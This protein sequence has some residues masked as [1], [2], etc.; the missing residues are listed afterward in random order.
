MHKY[1]VR[2]FPVQVKYS[3]LKSLFFRSRVLNID[4][5]I[6][7]CLTADLVIIHPTI[8]VY[9]HLPIINAHLIVSH[10]QLGNMASNSTPSSLVVERW[11]KIVL[12]SSSIV[13]LFGGQSWSNRQLIGNLLISIFPPSVRIG[14]SIQSS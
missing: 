6:L 11:Y 3:Q 10:L 9:T 8:T 7:G 13:L 2:H 4:M 14:P 1:N 12:L 5:D